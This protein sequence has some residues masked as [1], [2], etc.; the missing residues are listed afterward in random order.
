MKTLI[1]ASAL[2]LAS[3]MALASSWE[4]A[5]KNPDLNTG[6]YDKPS[7]LMEPMSSG[8]ITV[9]LDEFNRGNP[10]HS[11]HESIGIGA[12]GSSDGYATSL[13]QFNEGNPDHV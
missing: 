5:W 11:S 13:D 2:V 7:T 1:T 12:R 6:V 8:K 3:N 9:S 10:E 4:E